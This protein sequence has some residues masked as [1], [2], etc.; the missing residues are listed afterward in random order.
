[1]TVA[2]IAIAGVLLGFVAGWFG[3]KIRTRYCPD[4]GARLAC[5]ACAARETAVKATNGGKW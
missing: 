2:V 3:F 5:L 1:M 4:C